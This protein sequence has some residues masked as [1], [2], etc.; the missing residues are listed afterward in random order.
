MRSEDLM[1]LFELSDLPVLLERTAQ[2]LH[3]FGFQHVML[4]WYPA[5]APTATMENNSQIIW[6]NL[7]PD[8]REETSS[9]HAELTGAIAYCLEHMRQETL[10]RQ[11]WLVRQ[12]G[13]FRLT[14][15]PFSPDPVTRYEHALPVKYHRANWIESYLCPVSR[16]RDRVLFP[17]TRTSFPVSVES[18]M[19][20]R[21]VLLAFWYAYHCL[22]ITSVTGDGPNQDAEPSQP[23]SS[24]EIE[25]LHWLA[26]GKTIAES[27]IILGISDR[28]LRFHVNNARERLGVATTTQAIVAAT[29]KHGFHTSDARKSVYKISRQA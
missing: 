4:Q 15:N 27:A 2:S 10:D 1:D 7:D 8:F 6:H 13:P 5:P 23:L 17:I 3:Q 14:E 12:N 18:D 11:S 29:L 25:C 24:R 21:R 22:Y 26:A 28:T 16:E 20:V 19:L 9:L